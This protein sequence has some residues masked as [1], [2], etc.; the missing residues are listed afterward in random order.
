MRG[1]RWGNQAEPTWQVATPA[2]EMPSSA[3]PVARNKHAPHAASLAAGAPLANA[4]SALCVPPRCRAFRWAAAAA[5][6]VSMALA[7][8]CQAV[9]PGF[10]DV[11][12][13]QLVNSFG[14]IIVVIIQAV[15]LGHRLPLL[16][17][18]CSLVM[19]GGAVMVSTVGREEVCCACARKLELRPIHAMVW[20]CNATGGGP[21]F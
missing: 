1:P 14:V 17:W 9:A 4:C 5:I 15:L 13:V 8:G 18:P 20:G 12:I 7:G 3:Q 21:F 10:V 6:A 16:I 19:T 11:A 2:E